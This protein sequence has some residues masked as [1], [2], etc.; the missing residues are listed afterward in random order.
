MMALPSLKI[1][2]IDRLDFKM[3][4]LLMSGSAQIYKNKA[5]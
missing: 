3:L 4:D 1:R 2:P 5:Y